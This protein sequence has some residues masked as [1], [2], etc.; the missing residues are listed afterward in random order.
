[1]SDRHKR[2]GYLHRITAAWMNRPDLFP[3]GGVS[4]PTIAHDD[5][6]KR[7]KGKACNCYPHIIVQTRLGSF[8]IDHDGNVQPLEKNEN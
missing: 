1:M 7:L 3:Q 2:R 8:T 6:C 4:M 5:W